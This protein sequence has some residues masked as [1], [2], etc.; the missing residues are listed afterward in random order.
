MSSKEKNL[1]DSK[2]IVIDDS[3][4]GVGG[5]SLTLD[6]IIEPE[7]DNVGFISTQEFSLTQAFSLNPKK[8]IIGNVTNLTASVA[9]VL[10][11]LMENKPFVK[12]EFDYG[13]C[14]YRGEIPHKTLAKKDCRCPFHVESYNP[15]AK[16]YELIHSHGDYVFYMSDEQMQMHLDS[17]QFPQKST[18]LRLSSCFTAQSLESMSKLRNNP[19]NNRYAIIDGNGGWHTQAKGIEESKKYAIDHSLKFDIIKTST[20]KEMLK[21]LSEYSGMIFLPIIH[22]TCPR[23]TIEAKLLGLDVIT[24][25]KSQHISEEWWNKSLADIEY[26]LK[27]RPSYFW[28]ILNE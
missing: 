5:T 14:P 1:K 17:L 27:G 25:S 20:N 18:Y 19:K 22:D 10:F 3:V 7:K 26:Y 8:W 9:D 16:I 13:F 11:W 23:V 28:K 2:Y 24:H 21:L 15:L 6:G 4:Q 12:I